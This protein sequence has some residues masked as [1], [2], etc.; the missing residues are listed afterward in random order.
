MGGGSFERTGVLVIRAW[1]EGEPPTLRARLTGTSDIAQ[2]EQTSMT[3]AGATSVTAAVGR[4]LDEV[5]SGDD[6]VT[7]A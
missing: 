3:L 1:T 6:P 7:D 4:W 5:Q 2:G